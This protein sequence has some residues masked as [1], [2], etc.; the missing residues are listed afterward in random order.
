[1][2]ELDY[3][4]RYGYPLEE[5]MKQ[6]LSIKDRDRSNQI[7]TNV[8]QVAAQLE[9]SG[10]Y[11]GDYATIN[12][13][14]AET[15]NGFVF[16]NMIGDFRAYFRSNK[17]KFIGDNPL[18]ENHGLQVE[19]VRDYGRIGRFRLTFPIDQ[20]FRYAQQYHA[21]Q[22]LEDF[23]Q[24]SLNTSPPT[25]RI[26]PIHVAE[27]WT[28][29]FLKGSKQLLRPQ[30]FLTYQQLRQ[31]CA[32]FDHPWLANIQ[33]GIQGCFNNL[34]MQFVQSSNG[35]SPL[36]QRITAFLNRLMNGAEGTEKGLTGTLQQY[37]FDYGMDSCIAIIDQIIKQYELQFTQQFKGF[38][39]SS[40]ANPYYQQHFCFGQNDRN[41]L[42]HLEEQ[43]Q[44]LEQEL[45]TYA[46]GA[47]ALYLTADT[48]LQSDKT[49][50]E[51]E[52]NKLWKRITGQAERRLQSAEGILKRLIST[53]G[54]LY[55]KYTTSSRQYMLLY[56]AIQHHAMLLE[57]KQHLSHNYAM[58]QQMDSTN[59]RLEKG[60]L[61]TYKDQLTNILNEP[62]DSLEIRVVG[63]QASE[64]QEFAERL[65]LKG[66]VRITDK[67]QEDLRAVSD[68]LLTSSLQADTLA[69]AI[70]EATGVVHTLKAGKSI[71]Q[72]LSRKIEQGKKT[73][74][75][76]LL[77]Q[78]LNNAAYLGKLDT[79][80]V[81]GGNAQVGASSTL[82]QVQDS[83][84]ITREFA[85][86]M[87]NT[88][89][90]QTDNTE[91][92]IITKMETALPL[93]VF[94]EFVEGGQLY[95]QQ[96][97]DNP[98]AQYE[99]HTHQ[100]F[101][102]I[103]EPFG[104]PTEMPDIEQQLFLQILLQLGLIRIV[105]EEIQFKVNVQSDKAYFQYFYDRSK[106]KLVYQELE[107]RVSVTTLLA[108][109][110][111]NQAWFDFFAQRVLQRLEYLYSLTN[112]AT[113]QGVVDYL[114]QYF[115]FDPMQP[116]HAPCFPPV[117]LY[118]LI[119]Y[120]T[121]EQLRHRL[122]NWTP[123]N[124]RKF[125]HLKT[126]PA[127]KTAIHNSDRKQ[128]A[129]LFTVPTPF[130][131]NDTPRDTSERART[132]DTKGKKRSD[133]PANPFDTTFKKGKKYWVS[134]ADRV[135]K[136]RLPLEEIIPIILKD[137]YVMI[138][139]KS[140]PKSEQ[141]WKDWKAIK[142]LYKAVLKKKNYRNSY[143]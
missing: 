85:D 24:G 89:V 72:Y 125:Q 104:V 37:C 35:L 123:F 100:R 11:I 132:T 76:E 137:E 7:Y 82:I 99:K 36:E 129:A 53:A 51:K 1:M 112:A 31:T 21:V 131:I 117:L 48:A 28:T 14:V 13:S 57:L 80:M 46:N 77:L 116:K 134:T 127:F 128:L 133:I 140:K 69:E 68:S 27:E 142:G 60:L 136:E 49:A 32:T 109:L 94:K 119:Q 71:V 75:K 138:S 19:R 143:N 113:R 52:N 141:D 115:E 97:A 58:I 20:L 61:K 12:R 105:N 47:S 25:E 30:P 70:D 90:V 92:I 33:D 56:T 114:K 86:I 65:R 73:E 120:S 83:G 78:L 63:A 74:V 15:I 91:E 18:L 79:S 10:A 50:W 121:M 88:K 17:G 38:L 4:L 59:T 62:K 102:S 124:N 93:F 67:L 6:V 5:K 106:S 84:F 3:V 45:M 110:N 16:G 107:R 101:V 81:N 23:C 95:A 22:L 126:L 66:D 29:A 139:G 118:Y 54:Q 39:A 8:L 43:R 98:M 130:M 64:F 2:K 103:P 42:S 87:G 108:Q 26:A 135:Y 9:N 111:Q 55:D 41:L 44:V 40:S 122:T 96:T 34:A